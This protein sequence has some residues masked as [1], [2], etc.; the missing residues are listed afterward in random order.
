MAAPWCKEFY[1]SWLAR[2][3][4]LIEVAWDKVEDCGFVEGVGRYA[5]PCGQGDGGK[6]SEHEALE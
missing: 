4:D 3:G 6:T 1:E 5:G 2:D